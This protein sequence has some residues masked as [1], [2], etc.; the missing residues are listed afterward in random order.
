MLSPKR[1]PKSLEETLIR[2]SV[3]VLFGTAYV[4]E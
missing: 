2:D 1:I 3:Y 4:Q